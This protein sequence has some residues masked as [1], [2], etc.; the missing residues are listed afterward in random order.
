MLRINL[1]IE[2]KKWESPFQDNTIFGAGYV[3][4]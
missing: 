4:G 2:S 1:H 3:V